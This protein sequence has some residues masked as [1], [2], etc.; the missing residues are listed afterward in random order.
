MAD[1]TLIQAEQPDDQPYRD[2]TRGRSRYIRRALVKI[3]R[4]SPEDRKKYKPMDG[5][6]EAA[7]KHFERCLTDA[8]G[9]AAMAFLQIALGEKASVVEKE[10]K[11]DG[12]AFNGIEDDLPRSAKKPVQ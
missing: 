2:R 9:T 1:E 4:M 11:P 3:F 5:F 10:A 8:R 6:E 7:I 12:S